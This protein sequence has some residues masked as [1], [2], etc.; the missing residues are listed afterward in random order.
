MINNIGSKVGISLSLLAV[1]CVGIPMTASAQG[2]FTVTPLSPQ[3]QMQQPSPV[4]DRDGTALPQQPI[5]NHSPIH[6]DPP[7]SDTPHQPVI[8]VTAHQLNPVIHYGTANPMPRFPT[9]PSPWNYVYPNSDGS[10]GYNPGPVNN[11]PPV[12]YLG[13]Y[14]YGGYCNTPYYPG[15]YP[16]VYSTYTG[17]PEYISDPGVIVIGQ[18]YYPDYTTNSQPYYSNPSQSAQPT[19][20]TYNQ[21]NYN[22]NNYYLQPPATQPDT[23]KP[24]DTPK[25]ASFDTGSYRAAF[26]DIEK[27]WVDG[28][29]D[30]IQAHLR[31][32][33]T[34]VSVNLKGKYAYSIS[35]DDFAKITRDAFAD[36]NTVSFE[37]TRLRKAKNGDVTAYGTHTYLAVTQASAPASSK[38]STSTKTS[39]NDDT[40]TVP[41]D[42]PDSTSSKSTDGSVVSKKVYVSFTLR[43]S[44][45]QWYIVS[46]DSSTSPLVPDQD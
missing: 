20:V 12:T 19:T 8:T 38:S 15:T 27:A 9:W 33:D 5:S 10:L 18:P 32:S 7:R 22:T 35:S 45:S 44:D 41:F 14:Y 25:H 37:F 24:A 26:A 40:A 39:A 36:L 31:D 1:S 11:S 28:N 13:G 2:M 46:V 6:N 4:S 29:I 42:Q 43:Q 3:Q 34:K 21:N 23:S 17:L 16:S 30:L